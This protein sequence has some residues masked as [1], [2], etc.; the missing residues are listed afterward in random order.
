MN[1]LK[2]RGMRRAVIS[3]GFAGLFVAF[4]AIPGAATSPVGFTSATVARGTFMGHASLAIGH[5]LDVL[6]SRIMVTPGGSSGWHS[7]PGGAIAIVLQG[8][9]TVYSSIG[10]GDGEQGQNQ[11][12]KHGDRRH[13]NCVITR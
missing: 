8:E 13:P 2:R 12:D 11:S 4:N 10:K 6:V 1:T 5:G 7:H 9:L 3:L